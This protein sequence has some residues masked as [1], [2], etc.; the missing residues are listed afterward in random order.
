M[1]IKV[2]QFYKNSKGF[3]F[4]ELLVAIGIV[5]ILTSISVSNFQE[6]RERV[7]DITAK[8]VLR[9]MYTDYNSALVE[10]GSK[11]RLLQSLGVGGFSLFRTKSG[12]W[13]NNNYKQAVFP[14]ITINDQFLIG[15]LMINPGTPEFF[16]TGHCKTNR[17]VS[18]NTI[19]GWA[20]RPDIGVINTSVSMSGFCS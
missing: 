4:L 12:G 13:L 20:F 11:E 7:Y 6:Y 2:L 19:R 10:H 17:T 1:Q 8:Q 5:L 18:L 9:D 14:N 3:T 16:F 15:G